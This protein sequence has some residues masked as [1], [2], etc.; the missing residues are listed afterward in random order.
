MSR[1]KTGALFISTA[2]FLYAARFIAAAI[3]GCGVSSWNAEL[4][5]A[6]L[7]YVG[8][9]LWYAAAAFLAVGLVYL[10]WAETE[11]VKN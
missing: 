2:A 4:F 1:R 3:F 11:G 10:I 8:P 7:Q 5:S 6:M 9:E